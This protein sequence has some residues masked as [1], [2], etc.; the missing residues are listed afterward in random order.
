MGSEN[1]S[2]TPKLRF[3]G[4]TGEWEEK[5]AMDVCNVITSPLKLQSSDYLPSGKYPIVDQSQSL[6]CGWTNDSIGVIN[7]TPLIIFGDHTCALKYIDF[8]FV[9]GADGVKILTPKEKY[10][11]RFIYQTF[12]ANPVK[13]DGYK[14]HFS[15]FKEQIYMFPSSSAEQE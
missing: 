12:L 1:N 2:S 3:P 14:R 13:Q 15:D 5:N 10:I 9:Q 8:P 7:N 4:F 11:P 6:I